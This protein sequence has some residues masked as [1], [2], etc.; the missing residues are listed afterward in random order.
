MTFASAQRDQIEWPRDGLESVPACPVCGSVNRDVLYEGLTDR[1]FHCAPGVWTMKCCND[2][3][4]GYLDPRPTADT[5]HM[6][7][8]NY[9]THSADS[10]EEREVP[11]NFKRRL[12]N[13]YRNYR[14]GSN[15]QPA[16]SLGVAVLYSLP[17][18]RRRVDCSTR[19]LPRVRTDSRLLDVGFGGGEYLGLARSLGWRVAGVDPDRVAVENAK[20]SGLTVREGGA[21]AFMDQP[22]SFDAVTLNHIIEHVHDPRQTLRDVF[23]L[24][25]PGGFLYLETPNIDALGRRD[26]GEYWRG[27]EAPRHLTLFSWR[28]LEGLLRQIGFEIGSRYVRSEEYSPIAAKS[29]AIREG[30]DPYSGRPKVV[31]R[32][33]GLLYSLYLRF[34]HTCT[35]VITITAHK[36]L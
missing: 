25:K 33:R 17:A 23:D 31:D 16:A 30:S 10:E 7:Y 1:V 32:V 19:C 5:V 3:G 15:L 11:A 4:C 12:V 26:F 9:Y 13:G 35:E 21:E 6:A 28:S 29:R 14:F 2:C 24:L 27:I 36:P 22:A 18:L 8:E 34:N 20:A